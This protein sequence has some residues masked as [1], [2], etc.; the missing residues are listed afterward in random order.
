MYRIRGLSP[1]TFKPR[2]GKL[3]PYLH[4]E[5][6]PHVYQWLMD[7]EQGI[8]REAVDVRIVRPD[9]TV[10][11]CNVEARH[12]FDGGGRL[13]KL[14]GPL[15]D[16][17]ARRLTD[18]KLVQ[19][20]KMETI[21]ELSGGVAHDFN[22]VLSV[23]IGNLDLLRRQ[24][25]NDPVARKLCSEAARSA[26]R[27]ADLTRRLLAYARRQPLRPRRTNV[28]DLVDGMARLLG[29]MLGEN[30]ILNL[31]LDRRTSPVVVDPTQLEAALRNL[32]ANA[33]DAMP[34]GGR[35]DITTRNA[36]IDAN[37]AVQHSEVSQG[38]YAM[39]EVS[40]SGEGIPPDII[41]QIFEPF[42]T[43][44]DPGN[45]SGLGLSM[46][47]G[48]I[49]QSGG[50]VTV[51]SEAGLGATFRLYLPREADA[52]RDTEH[53]SSP[54]AVPGGIE[55]ILVVEDNADLR[56]VTAQGLRFRGY[57][58][59]EAE[60]A[61]AAIDVLKAHDDVQLLFADFVLPGGVDGVDLAA[62]AGRLRPGLP[63]LLT[64]GLPDARGTGKSKKVMASGIPLLNKPYRQD[65]LA[66]A[67]REALDE[68][69]VESLPVE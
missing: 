47:F 58:V 55:T 52:E 27:G 50:H 59:R 48:F 15:P 21:D 61:A 24:I 51:H 64:S 46:V 49:K 22:N 8:Q 36:R 57:Q 67:V 31:R 20:Q 63:V 56:H 16:L 39:I 18:Q 44:K 42:F 43:T 37:Y 13:R 35:L 28:N 65:E 19:A 6:R 26:H 53:D 34:D 30:V 29:R 14:I 62:E 69:Q 38:D 32:T 9:G 60:T 12:V 45:G 23:I 10:R 41:G 5:D 4:E 2:R 1:E 7:M 3:A 54:A 33:R 25:S 40:D 68:G 11:I 66:I 17:P